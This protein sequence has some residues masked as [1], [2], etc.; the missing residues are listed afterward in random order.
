MSKRSSTAVCHRLILPL[1]L[2][3]LMI[4]KWLNCFTLF[5]GT[6]NSCQN[7]DLSNYWRKFRGISRVIQQFRNKKSRKTS[8]AAFMK[9]PPQTETS[10]KLIYIFYLD[11]P[12]INNWNCDLFFNCFTITKEKMDALISCQMRQIANLRAWSIF[13]KCFLATLIFTQMYYIL[14]NQQRGFLRK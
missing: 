2:R 11:L 14:W 7:I 8:P 9:A 1:S 10:T 4:L 13:L 5:Y 3:S 12:T 6:L